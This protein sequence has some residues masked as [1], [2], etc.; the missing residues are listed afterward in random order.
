MANLIGGI[1]EGINV[2]D[3]NQ[4]GFDHL[5][6]STDTVYEYETPAGNT[7]QLIGSGFLYN[8]SGEPFA[9]TVTAMVILDDLG[10][11]IAS[12]VLGDAS[13]AE[14][15]ADNLHDFWRE[16]LGGDDQITTGWQSDTIN[17]FDGNDYIH[18]NAGNDNIN[19][20]DGDDELNGG[21][22]YD[23]VEGGLGNDTIVFNAIA[24]NDIIDGGAG[25]DTVVHNGMGSD[26]PDLIH[27]EKA[28]QAMQMLEVEVG[29]LFQASTF[30]KL[31]DARTTTE[32]GLAAKQTRTDD[33]GLIGGKKVLSP[34][35]T[36]YDDVL[37]RAGSVTGTGDPW[38]PARTEAT[39]SGVENIVVN[40][41]DGNDT[42]TVH[43]LTDTLLENGHVF[44]DGG[45]GD[46]NLNG[47]AS[48]TSMTY[49]WHWIQGEGDP[50]DG[51]V[52]FGSATDDRFHFLDETDD[53]HRITLDAFA[54]DVR[55]WEG[56]SGFGV[57]PDIRISNAEF[58]DFD[59]GGGDDEFYTDTNLTG[60]YGGI[61]DI[62][63]GEGDAD[64]DTQSHS[65]RIEVIGGTGHNAFF[66]GGGDDLL[67][68]GDEHDDIFGGAGADEI[69]GLGGDD[70]IGGGEGDDTLTGGAGG[71][72]FFFEA[73]S[74]I[75]T[76]TDF[77]AGL[78][79]NDVLDFLAYGPMD[80]NDLD[81]SQVGADT[82]ITTTTGDT[83]ILANVLTTDLDDG[84]FLFA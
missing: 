33:G 74:G 64:L 16:L 29:Q 31:L 63:F 78:A 25:D 8:K 73:G 24:G 37:L 77:E 51:D 30:G 66:A 80:Q 69:N 57:T 39:I 40:G 14:M 41:R 67:I 49:L 17:G 53:G 76:I 3:W 19:G 22:G 68:G 10:N 20:G 62:D 7:V 50:G 6:S 34:G 38:E 61:L 21:T 82:H 12:L 55:L 47:A 28:P 45:D 58:L 44:F 15:I 26:W 59:F 9:G 70:D 35:P 32:F 13:L 84:D 42:L 54:T 75:D 1:V 81:I 72:R 2:W 11:Q 79:G 4:W 83:V 46:D 56:P 48:S 27:I 71:D 52:N 43:D 18:G 36:V 65:G 23:F 60:V 5:I